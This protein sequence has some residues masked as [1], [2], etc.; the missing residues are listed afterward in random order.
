M[1]AKHPSACFSHLFHSPP[2]PLSTYFP[3]LLPLASQ[4]VGYQY[5]PRAP[6]DTRRGSSAV[7]ELGGTVA[8]ANAAAP[9]ARFTYNE[10]WVPEEQPPPGQS[11]AVSD[12]GDVGNETA[13]LASMIDT[14]IFTFPASVASDDGGS[15]DGGGSQ[16][17]S[18]AANVPMQPFNV[19]GEKPPPTPAELGFL[20]TEM[21]TEDN[22]AKP[23]GFFNSVR[24]R[25]RQA[26]ASPALLA[27]GSAEALL[28]EIKRLKAAKAGMSASV[29]ARQA[30]RQGRGALPKYV[31]GNGQPL[32]KLPTRAVSPPTMARQQQKQQQKQQPKQQQLSAPQQPTKKAKPQGGDA[33]SPDAASTD[34]KRLDHHTSALAELARSA[35]AARAE[36][37]HAGDEGTQTAPAALSRSAL[38]SIVQRWGRSR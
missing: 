36:T 20:S 38:M 21:P 4:V 18:T 24:E 25:A 11:A 12:D 3:H 9:L 15:Q 34:L 17:G 26:G 16:N 10:S 22:P 35:Q 2:A 5:D 28:A 27:A 14:R 23:R 32:P 33:T 7:A 31:S 13:T 37:R 1:A 19:V 30:A 8:A 29:A 6:L